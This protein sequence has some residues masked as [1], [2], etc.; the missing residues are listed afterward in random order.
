[1]S[2]EKKLILMIIT[3]LLLILGMVF[4]IIRPN[5]LEIKN[6]NQK[7]IKQRKSLEELYLKGQTITK[8]KKELKE[9]EEK[10]QL[11]KNIFLKE[12]EELKFITSLEK[13]AK[14]NEIIQEIRLGEKQNFKDEYK[15]IPVQLSLRGD[16]FDLIRYFKEIENFDFYFNIDSLNILSL[17][18]KKEI[19][20]SLTAKT[21]WRKE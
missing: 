18:E 4:F 16:F 6:L 9:I 7:I 19:N 15:L 17:P 5:V 8:V 14:E 10:D 13:I 12:G 2:S 20:V 11:L 3:T 1:M 21:Y